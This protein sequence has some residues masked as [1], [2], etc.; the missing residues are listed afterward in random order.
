M[1][2]LQGDEDWRRPQGRW[3]WWVSG[4]LTH[5]RKGDSVIVSIPQ[6]RKMRHREDSCPL[7]NELVKWQSGTPHQGGL[8]PDQLW[9]KACV[10]VFRMI[11][12][13]KDGI[14]SGKE[15]LLFW[16]CHFYCTIEQIV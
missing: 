15:L 1:E 8:A 16:F 5:S 14:M 11:M 3:R 4:W 9:I 12:V 10:C 7:H 2:H 13:A 6:I